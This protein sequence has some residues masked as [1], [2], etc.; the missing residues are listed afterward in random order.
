MPKSRPLPPPPATLPCS[1]CKGRF[2]LDYDERGTPTA[3]H[4][5]P[6]CEAFNAIE[7]SVDGIAHFEKCKENAK[8]S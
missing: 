8:G 1:S 3:Y 5:L 7:T 6:Y 2:G 4:T